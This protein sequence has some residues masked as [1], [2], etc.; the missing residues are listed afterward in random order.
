MLRT[1][2]PPEGLGEF[3]PLGSRRRANGAQKQVPFLGTG[4][5]RAPLDGDGG[6]V[7][8][9]R[10]PIPVGQGDRL[11]M[12]LT[13]R[14]LVLACDESLAGLTEKLFHH[15]GAFSEQL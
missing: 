9:K 3:V 4:A 5:K 12:T 13:V 15:N 10:V 8:L 14:F 2:M 6:L 7:V 1:E 11:L